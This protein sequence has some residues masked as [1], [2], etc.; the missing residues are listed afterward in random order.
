VLNQQ[1][2]FYIRAVHLDTIE[3]FY[4][5]TN[6]QVIVLKEYQYIFKVIHPLSDVDQIYINN[7]IYIYFS[8]YLILTDIYLQL[9]MKQQKP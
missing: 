3:V 1:Y 6:A 4:L 7:I 5:P 8:V 9:A 2:N